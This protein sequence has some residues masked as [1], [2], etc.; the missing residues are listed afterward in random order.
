MVNGAP[1]RLRI[2][3]L[4]AAV[5]VLLGPG[6]VRAQTAE[7]E[8]PAGEAAARAREQARLCER[9][10]GEEAIA[11]CRQALAL[12]IGPSRRAGIR[13]LLSRRLAAVERWDQLAALLRVSVELD[14]GDAVAWRRLGNVLLFGLGRTED[15]VVA[16]GEAVHLAPDEAAS[17]CDLA[18]AL[19]SA[20]RLSE[21]VAA[22]DA[23]VRLDPAVLESRPAARAVLEAARE[24]R[25]WP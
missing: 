22:F 14:P 13:Q 9:L 18:V 16:L 5:A 4:V 1:R 3:A 19:A 24:G 21:A 10:D 2:A 25:R 12:G 7:A 20:G 17:R 6:P 8:A 11:A 23:A 15:A